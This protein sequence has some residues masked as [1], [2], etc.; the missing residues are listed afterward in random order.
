MCSGRH[1][2]INCS[3]L[4]ATSTFKSSGTLTLGGFGGEYTH[5]I[6]GRLGLLA[7]FVSFSEQS[8]NWCIRNVISSGKACFEVFR[9]RRT[10]KP[11]ITYP[12]FR[13]SNA[14]NTFS[15]TIPFSS[16]KKLKNFRRATLNS[17]GVVES[18]TF[19]LHQLLK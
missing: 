11:P 4:S 15:F 3:A 10:A 1:S 16:A 13:Y 19:L 7:I 2:S 9:R 14:F 18:K 8:L 17:F 6:G 5:I 12:L